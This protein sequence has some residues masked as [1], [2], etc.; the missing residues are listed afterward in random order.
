[1]ET[2]SAVRPARRPLPLG[3]IGDGQDAIARPVRAYHVRAHGE[4]R[5][6]SPLVERELLPTGS[7]AG[8]AVIP[9]R[10]RRLDRAHGPGRDVHRVKTGRLG[11]AVLES[12]RP[13]ERDLAAVRRSPG[14][15]VDDQIARKLLDPGAVDLRHIGDAGP[16]LAC[17]QE[18][19]L[20]VGGKGVTAY[21]GER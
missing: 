5:S 6:V 11:T 19:L 4:R 14:G 9:A 8:R 17:G 2:P 16:I 1:A 13:H 21:R 12:P 20:A 10:D 15:L 18:D 7:P 3:C